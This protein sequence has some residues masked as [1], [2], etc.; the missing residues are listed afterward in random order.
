MTTDVIAETLDRFA[1][2]QRFAADWQDVLRRAGETKLSTRRRPRKRW[3][4]AA[5]L[6]LAIVSPLGAIAAGDEWGFFRS[7]SPPATTPEVL[8][9]GSW[10]GHG[11][12]LVGYRDERRGICFTVISTETPRTE[13]RGRAMACGG[14]PEGHPRGSDGQGGMGSLLA[15][16]GGGPGV[17]QR[18]IAGPAIDG[19]RDMAIHL[20]GGDVIRTPT[21][22]VPDSMGSVVFYAAP[23]PDT[24]EVVRLIGRAADGRVIAC[25][26][27]VGSVCD[28]L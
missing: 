16:V 9:T 12:E 4:L 19:T 13:Q 18:Y 26:D 5:S 17:S 7:M 3:L 2:E 27:R 14:S 21:F 28:E 24:A 10:A 22:D 20:A 15:Y 25:S 6:L 23:L 11:W 1:P 8:Q